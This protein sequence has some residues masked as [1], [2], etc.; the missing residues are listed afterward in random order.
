MYHV[1]AM[2][3]RDTTKNTSTASMHDHKVK[4]TVEVRA[5]TSAGP[6]YAAKAGRR[7]AKQAAAPL[8]SQP[9]VTSP[10]RGTCPRHRRSMTL[11]TSPSRG[12]CPQ[13]R[14]SMTLTTSPSRGT[15][16]RHR[17]SMVMLTNC[18]EKGP[19]G[20]ARG[21][22]RLLSLFR[23]GW[24]RKKIIALSQNGRR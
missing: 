6:G 11:T 24:A 16:P 3:T 8:R 13:H 22:A 18:I 14:R 2:P 17:R 20:S 23:G 12:T 1:V 10:S 19:L 5:T 21:E 15:C 9:R 7:G 4:M